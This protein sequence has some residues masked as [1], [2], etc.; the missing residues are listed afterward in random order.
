MSEN[1]DASTA[2]RRIGKPA[3]RVCRMFESKHMGWA[4]LAVAVLFPFVIASNYALSI[5]TTAIIF[6]LLA[7]GLNMV[8]GYCGLLDLGY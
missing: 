7:S 3:S 4:A 8:V 5:G 6:V 2:P 1:V